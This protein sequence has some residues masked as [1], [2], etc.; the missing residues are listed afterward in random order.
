MSRIPN[1]ISV[2][3]CKGAAI[4]AWDAASPIT[5]FHTAGEWLD[6]M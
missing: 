1:E 4:A 5:V 6:L 3:A 2:M